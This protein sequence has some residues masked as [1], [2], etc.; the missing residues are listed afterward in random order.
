MDGD[1]FLERR[2]YLCLRRFGPLGGPSRRAISDFV[3]IAAAP[4]IQR[5]R[6]RNIVSFT[7]ILFQNRED[8]NEYNCIQQWV[9]IKVSL[10]FKTH[11]IISRNKRSE[12]QFAFKQ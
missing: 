10:N 12:K 6:S 4:P 2:L 7:P 11:S 3:A 8:R 9:T 1:E 5:L